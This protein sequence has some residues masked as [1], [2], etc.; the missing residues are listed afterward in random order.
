MTWGR[1]HG[2]TSYFSLPT[3]DPFI[4]LPAVAKVLRDLHDRLVRNESRLSEDLA[5]CGVGDGDAV[6]VVSHPGISRGQ[7]VKRLR[8]L[9][10]GI[11]LEDGPPAPSFELSPRMLAGSALRGGAFSHAAS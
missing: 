4:E 11:V 9:W 2:A 3:A 6:H 7:V 1:D 5:F 10:P 8:V